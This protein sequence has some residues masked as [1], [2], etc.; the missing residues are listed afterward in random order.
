MVN[1]IVMFVGLT[2]VGV[3]I[4]NMTE[5]RPLPRDEVILRGV[6]YWDDVQET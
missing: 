2:A 4:Y 3:G 1:K 5:E 6:E